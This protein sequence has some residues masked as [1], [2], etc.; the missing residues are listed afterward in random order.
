LIFFSLP[1]V[2]TQQ[3]RHHLRELRTLVAKENFRG[4]CQR[5]LP[6]LVAKKN[7]ARWWPKRTFSA[8]AERE[9]RRQVAKEN[10]KAGARRELPRL[11]ASIATCH[12]HHGRNIN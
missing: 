2:L 4:W 8:G 1:A 5:E 6:R 7:F 10:F 12:S 11:V 9:L 3:Q